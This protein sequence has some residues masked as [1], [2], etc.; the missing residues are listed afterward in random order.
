MDSISGIAFARR[1]SR[2]L[3]R[4]VPL[5]AA[6]RNPSV[7]RLSQWLT[8]SLVS[9]STGQAIVKSLLPARL[10]E[11][12]HHAAIGAGVE[13]TNVLPCTPL[14][15][16]MLSSSSEHPDMYRNTIRFQIEGNLDRL[17]HCW[18]QLF[19][20]HD[21]LRTTFIT[22]GDSIYP[23]VQMVLARSDFPWLDSSTQST[24][25]EL[26]DPLPVVDSFKPAIHLRIIQSGSAIYLQFSCHHALYDG[27][28]IAILLRELEDL[29]HG[30][31]L[32]PVV[33]S[34]SF[35]QEMVAHRD[36]NH[37]KFWNEH[38]Q[39]LQPSILRTSS[40]KQ[41]LVTQTVSHSLSSLESYCHGLSVS[42]L[43]LC[44][45]AWAKTL[46][47]LF[48]TSD[49]C[50]GNVFSGR[51]VVPDHMERLVAPTFNTVPFRID[52]HQQHSN[53]A[54]MKAT[55]RINAACL[56][57]QLTP[58]R[59]IQSNLGFAETGI[60]SSILLL[61]HSNLELDPSI[62]KLKHEKGA[63]NVGNFI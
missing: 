56:N 32:Y 50:F 26:S 36:I 57:H 48:G 31:S 1:L 54:T 45:T 58:L 22:T 23:F 5:S 7:A 29:Y 4:D 49:I 14:Q 25:K 30:R 41:E 51:S 10:I 33:S 2:I 63:M 43:S 19:S 55:Q 12:A 15:E 59:L 11:Q 13:V 8:T 34:N 44:Q 60:F 35:L 28:A 37:L 40:W 17:K 20:R 16:A 62:W 9:H 47:S 27:A 53:L 18:K 42:L 46:S 21:I 39:D 38:L 52:L 6:L 3:H 24:D 61:Q